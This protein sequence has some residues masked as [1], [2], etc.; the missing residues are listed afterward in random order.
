MVVA[1]LAVVVRS[2]LVQADFREA[3]GIS[4]IDQ[5]SNG[6]KT[7]NLIPEVKLAMSD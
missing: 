1:P 3:K 7:K 6:M 4:G 5:L 2:G